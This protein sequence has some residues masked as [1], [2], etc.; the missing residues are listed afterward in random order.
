[1]LVKDK[2]ALSIFGNRTDTE[3]GIGLIGTHKHKGPYFWCVLFSNSA[4]N[5]TFVL[6][7]LGKGIEQKEGCYSGKSIGCSR[8]EKKG[9]LFLSKIWVVGFLY[10]H[11]LQ[12]LHF[13]L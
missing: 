4:R 2:K 11:F 13:G 1:M 7:D 12:H 6:E 8:G 9:S 5:T 3:V 10:I